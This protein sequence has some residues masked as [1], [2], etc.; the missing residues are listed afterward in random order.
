MEGKMNSYEVLS[1]WAEADSIPWRGITERITDLSGKKIGLLV[2]SK[3]TAEPSLKV[4][5]KRLKEKFPDTS[6][7]WFYNLKANEIAI[8]T[9]KKEDFEKWLEE[10]DTVINSYGD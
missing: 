6:F 3:R 8:A 2:N 1:P 9:D 10:V 4:V 7:S 5:E